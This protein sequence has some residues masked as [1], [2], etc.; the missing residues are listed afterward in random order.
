MIIYDEKKMFK[1]ISESSS[2]VQGTC[3]MVIII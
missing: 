1:K 2:A 3:Y